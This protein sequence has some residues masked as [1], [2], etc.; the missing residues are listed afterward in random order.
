[1]YDSKVQEEGNNGK[2]I[3]LER[4]MILLNKFGG[5]VDA[6]ANYKSSKYENNLSRGCGDMRPK[7]GK[8]S[9]QKKIA[10]AHTLTITH[11]IVGKYLSQ[12]SPSYPI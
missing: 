10:Y 8:N 2:I 1:M 4:T 9:G 12:T 6:D 11:N 3:S 7:K 5:W